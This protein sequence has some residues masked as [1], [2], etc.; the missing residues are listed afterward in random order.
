VAATALD[1]V[2]RDFGTRFAEGLASVPVGQWSGPV[3][4]AY[5]L[6]LVRLDARTP[7]GVPPLAEIRPQVAREWE[8]ERRTKAREA[9][10]SELRQAYDVV[11][12]GVDAPPAQ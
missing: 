9:R 3:P 10:M 4:S 2:A 12:E 6:H 1:L 7:A 11:I 8:N 5:G